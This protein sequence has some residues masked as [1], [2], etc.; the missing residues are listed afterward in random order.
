MYLLDTNHCS[1]ILAG[2]SAVVKRVIQVGEQNIATCVIVRG[3]LMYM[4][5]NSGR[6]T[7]NLNQVQA[8][9][10]DIRLYSVDEQTADLYGELKGAVMRYFGSKEKSKRR[11]VTMPHLGVS[12]NDLWI[13]SIALQHNLTVVS[14]DTDFVRLRQA[15][16]FL[17]EN[18]LT[19]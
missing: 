12:D 19:S 16:P 15:H 6:V 17:L 9:L 1:S 8:F 13:A 11:H 10:A 18:W 2:E 3:E 4:A 14:M 7:E 5:Y